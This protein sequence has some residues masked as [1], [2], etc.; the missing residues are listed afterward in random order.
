LQDSNVIELDQATI[1]PLRSLI[2][3]PELQTRLDTAYIRLEDAV[4]HINQIRKAAAQA[5]QEAMRADG[6]FAEALEWCGHDSK[7][8]KWRW[9]GEHVL[10]EVPSAEQSA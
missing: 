7:L 1:I 2:L 5:E 9:D 4:N 6:R 3:T 8:G 10:I